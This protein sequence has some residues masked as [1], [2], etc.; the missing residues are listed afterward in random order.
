MGS[1]PSILENIRIL[2]V[3]DNADT[4][5][6]I[7]RFLAEQ[8]AQVFAAKNA[9]EGLRLVRET[10][11]NVVVSDINMPGRNGFEFLVD[12]RTLGK[13]SGGSV[14]VIAMTAYAIDDRVIV[15]AGFQ[16]A[17]RKPFAPDQLLATIHLVL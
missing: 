6:L 13:N 15:D 5:F 7:A 16:R 8:G 3:E 12:I 14:P 9:F 2:V 17:L 1:S 10:R 11:P 4:R